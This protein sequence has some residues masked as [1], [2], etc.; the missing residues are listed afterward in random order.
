MENPVFQAA[1][2]FTLQ[3]E[4]GYVIHPLD[5]GGETNCGISK[6]SYPNLDI[7]SLT[8]SDVA[9]IYYR[10]FWKGPRFNRIAN[11][12]LATK[13]FDLGVLVS[14][15]RAAKFLQRAVSI[16]SQNIPAQR[17]NSWR[18]KIARVLNNKPLLVD[19]I[20]G[21]ITLEVIA[22]CPYPDA[23]LAAMK[24]EA[25]DHFIVQNKPTFLPGWLERLEGDA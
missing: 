25:C 8:T 24:A 18:Q 13:V 9:R 15:R 1:L 5:P 17:R 20:I 2:A 11:H 23:I 19:G 6:R 16:V 4:G 10:D 12:A 14:P 7:K 21:P 3:H 22:L